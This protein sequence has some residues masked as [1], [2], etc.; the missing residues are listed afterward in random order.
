MRSLLPDKIM[1]RFSMAVG[2]VTGPW[3]DA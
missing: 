3:P 1:A 2:A